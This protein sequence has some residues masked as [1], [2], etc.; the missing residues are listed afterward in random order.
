MNL[1]V[2]MI[3]A[4]GRRS[5]A[6]MADRL[7][8]MLD[9]PLI[10]CASVL[11]SLPILYLVVAFALNEDLVTPAKNVVALCKLAVPLFLLAV[12]ITG[13]RMMTYDHVRDYLWACES[14]VIQRGMRD[15]LPCVV[16]LGLSLVSQMIVQATVLAG[17]CDLLGRTAWFCR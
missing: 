6:A 9:W 3:V 11:A 4:V 14:E 7:L 12:P 13:F 16:A 10:I 15:M 2:R 8:A 1:D 5:G 17:E